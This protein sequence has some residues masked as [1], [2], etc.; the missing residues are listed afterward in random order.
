M[1]DVRVHMYHE[2]KQQ[3]KGQGGMVEDN[4]LLQQMGDMMLIQIQIIQIQATIH[5][6]MINE[7]DL[8]RVDGKLDDIF[9]K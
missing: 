6:L 3:T 8:A 1:L 9:R 4:S 2:D 7:F 5:T